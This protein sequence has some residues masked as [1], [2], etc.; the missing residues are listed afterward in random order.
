MLLETV[1]FAVISK[2]KSLQ[3]NFVFER[4]KVV[5]AKLLFFKSRIQTLLV[6]TGNAG[7]VWPTATL[8][9]NFW[10]TS[11]DAVYTYTRLVGLNSL[12]LYAAGICLT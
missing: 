7:C 10:K 5:Y 2:L 1:I 4:N 9:P 6:L 12:L 3:I 8:V 11:C